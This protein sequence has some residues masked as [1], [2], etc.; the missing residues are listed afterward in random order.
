MTGLRAHL[1]L[2]PAVA[3][4]LLVIGSGASAGVPV[5]DTRAIAEAARTAANSAEQVNRLTELRGIAQQTLKSIGLEGMT[6]KILESPQWEEFADGGTAAEGL[7]QFAPNTCAIVACKAEDGG[8]EA[9]LTDLQS[10]RD[11]VLKNFYSSGNPTAADIRD[12]NEVRARARREAALNGYALSLYSRA[13]IAKADENGANLED[14]MASADSLRA[15]VQANTAILLAQYQQTTQVLALLTSLVETEAANAMA[16]D[17]DILMAQGGTSAPDVHIDSDYT[18][19]GSRRTVSATPEG[20]RVSDDGWFGGVIGG[21]KPGDVFAGAKE[22]SGGDEQMAGWLTELEEA[23]NS[24]AKNKLFWKSAELLAEASGD[25]DLERIINDA[26]SAVRTRDPVSIDNALRIAERTARRNGDWEAARQ[27]ADSRRLV[28]AGQKDGEQATREAV[29]II[30][31][32]AGQPSMGRVLNKAARADDINEMTDVS[33]DVTE[34]LGR[35]T[36][37]KDVVDYTRNARRVK[38]KLD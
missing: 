25:R 15:D 2:A 27:I 19:T 38:R 36:G 17:T 14:L 32:H 5:F 31:K 4:A 16:G 28:R 22:A 29:T 33:I 34:E 6:A 26:E 12:Y 24:L 37:N 11:W 21:S 8:E 13:Q 10:A 35:M 3:G 18:I 1:L 7:R 9:Q 23:A 20:E 30:A